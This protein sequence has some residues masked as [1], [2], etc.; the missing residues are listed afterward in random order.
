MRTI[1]LMN[2]KGGC[3]KTTLATNIASGYADDGYKV[4]LADYD[5]QRSSLDW[6]EA[7]REH[8][9]V[10]EIRGI[11]PLSGPLR[12]SSNTDLLVID[13]PAG[14][15]GRDMNLLLKR[16]QTVILPVMPSAIDMRAARRFLEELYLNGRISDKKTRIAI[17]ANRVRE[18]TRIYQELEQFL[19]HLKLPF[20]GHLRESQSYIRA[21]EQGLGL[22]E[23]PSSTTL[24]DLPQWDP[25]FEWLD[26]RRALPVN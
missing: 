8:A 22:F 2:A 1:M 6:L 4:V 14:T 16:V 23:L 19:G 10:P 24:Q 9:E 21:A 26:S 11:D 20:I 25:I 18:N 12:V 7:R 5:P 3:G 13:A 17:V 15:H